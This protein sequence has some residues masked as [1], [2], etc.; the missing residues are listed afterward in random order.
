MPWLDVCFV[1]GEG[2][3]SFFPLLGTGGNDGRLEFTNNFMQRLADVIPFAQ[4]GVPATQSK[5]SLASALFA[6]TLVELGK[7][8]IGQFNPGGI[9]GANGTQGRFEADSRV[10]AWDFV[11]MIEGALLLAGSV[12]RRLGAEHPW[13]R[14]LPVQRG[15]GRRGI[16]IGH[17]KRRDQRWL[18]VR[19]VAAVMVRAL[20]IRGGQALIRRGP[21]SIRSSAG[22]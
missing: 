4:D 3:P 11:L 22:Q 21:S 14:S 9:G 17:R 10:N 5:R 16:R 20:D 6:D 12:A 2:G 13:T 7:S 18:A 15:I 8:A 19:A 1:L